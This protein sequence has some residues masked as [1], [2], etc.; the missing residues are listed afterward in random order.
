M[1]LNLAPE[2]TPL[3][4]VL[5]CLFGPAMV[6][7]GLLYTVTLGTLSPGL[8]LAVARLIAKARLAAIQEDCRRQP[9]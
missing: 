4:W 7:D 5:R 6:I 9:G 1:K 3:G 8:S 2:K